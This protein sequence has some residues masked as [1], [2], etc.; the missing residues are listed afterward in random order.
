METIKDVTQLFIVEKQTP[1]T[2]IEGSVISVYT[3][4]LDG[5]VVVTNY[6]NIVLDGAEDGASLAFAG[7]DA[8]KLIARV[9]D[10]LIHSDYVEKGTVK[11]WTV[12]GQSAEVQQVDYVGSNGVAG[13]LDAIASNIYTVRLYVVGSTITDFMQQKIKEGFYKS[14]AAA[15]SYTQ[16]RVALGLYDSLIANFSREPE[17]EIRFGRINSGARTNLGT[18]TT[19]LTFTQGSK[20]VSCAGTIEDTTG[21]TILIVGEYI[22]GGVAVTLPV[23]KIVSIDIPTDTLILDRP[24]QEATAT[25][26]DDAVG[27]IIGATWLAADFGIKLLGLDRSYSAGI[28]KSAVVNFKT[29]IDF[30]VSQVTTVNETTAAYPGIGTAQQVGSLEK[31]LQADNHVYRVFGAQ[32]GVTDNKQVSDSLVAAGEVYDMCVLEYAAKTVSGPGVEI[33]SP[34]TIQIAGENS[35]NLSMSDANQGVVQT[36]DEILILW[37]F[38][39]AADRQDANLT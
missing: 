23:Y 6:K 32:A 26:L 22:A 17:Q 18:A 27:R 38:M 28:F 36:I 24:Y 19:S 21:G 3:D 10:Q 5:E 20:T 31:E 30:G 33:Q 35:T 25:V 34:K 39:V 4:L 14:N 29:T 13:A 11:G 12:T 37:G 15:A 1:T 9:G 2:D 7:R 8:F 16:E